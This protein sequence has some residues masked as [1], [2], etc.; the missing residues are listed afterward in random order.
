[1]SGR[2]DQAEGAGEIIGH[3]S[4]YGVNDSAGSFEGGFRRS[5][6]NA[7]VAVQHHNPVGSLGFQDGI[8]EI[9]RMGALK[10]FAT[11]AVWLAP[12]QFGEV[13]FR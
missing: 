10:R 4:V 6:A 13:W 7:C 3:D 5:R 1:M 12:W 8:N 2:A 9:C 11:G